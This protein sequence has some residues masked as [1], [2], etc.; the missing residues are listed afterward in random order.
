[1]R[2]KKLRTHPGREKLRLETLNA[3]AVEDVVDHL[4][5]K[6]TGIVAEFSAASRDA[7]EPH[8]PIVWRAK[9]ANYAFEP[10][11]DDSH[12]YC[13]GKGFTTE[14]AWRSC[15]GEAAERY[16]G[17]RWI[18]EEL[19]VSTRFD[20]RGPSIDPSELVLYRPDQYP[21]LK[22]SPYSVDTELTWIQGW[23]LANEHPI[24]VPAIAAFMEFTIRDDTEFIA[25]IT[26]N[27]LAAGAKL[28][29]AVLAAIYEVLERDAFLI[30]WMN[31]LPSRVLDASSHPDQAVRDLAVLYE[32]RGV[33]LALFLLPT[34]HPASVVMAI[35]FQEGGFGGPA[36]TVGLGANLDPTVAARH[37]ALE[38]GQVRPAFRERARS[39]DSARIAELVN[40]P[41]LVDTMEDHSLLYAAPEMLG[42]FDFLYGPEVRWDELAYQSSGDAPLDLLIDHFSSTGQDVV[43]VNLSS[44]DIEPLGL[45]AARAIL[46]SFQP[47]WFGQQ[48]A[49]LGGR[50]LY[51]LPTQLG[52]RDEVATMNSLNILPHPLA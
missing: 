29:D 9:L 40:D 50:R 3:V 17:G 30:A 37:A 23:S 41:G 7:T 42:S 14:D 36:A 13:S 24:W 16:S 22:Y 1:M 39:R 5:S 47:I 46:P 26:S 18:A 48:E 21:K 32:R 2:K 20:L 25:P 34:D 49:R 27:G 43:Y 52:L 38:V 10:T 45:Y 44:P 4:V 11:P 28:G 35:A 15:L 31:R 19:T 51:E 6:R 33:R 8:L 12:L